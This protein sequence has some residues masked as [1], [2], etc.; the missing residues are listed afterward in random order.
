VYAK[1][2][3]TSLTDTV[4]VPVDGRRLYVTLWS[5]V[6]GTWQQTNYYYDTTE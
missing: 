2:E 1:L 6:N 3:G 4:S 5:N